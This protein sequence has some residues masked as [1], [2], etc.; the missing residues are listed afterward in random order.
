MEISQKQVLVA[1]CIGRLNLNVI[2][3]EG[4]LSAE[5]F[6]FM[7]NLWIKTFSMGGTFCGYARLLD[8]LKLRHSFQRFQ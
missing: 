3:F 7:L 4:S 8:N 2:Y 5:S 6:R 1:D